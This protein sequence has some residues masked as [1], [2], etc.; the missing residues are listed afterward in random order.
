[1]YTVD[2]TFRVVRASPRIKLISVANR[3]FVEDRKNFSN[4]NWIRTDGGK[5]ITFRRKKLFGEKPVCFRY[6]EIKSILETA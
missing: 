5:K 6:A 3:K 4:V 1:M 2:I